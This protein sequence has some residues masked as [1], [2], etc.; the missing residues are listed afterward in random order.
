[1][2]CYIHCVLLLQLLTHWSLVEGVSRLFE[3]LREG[4]ESVFP[5]SSL[6]SFYPEEVRGINILILNKLR[7]EY[8]RVLSI[9]FLIL[10]APTPK[11]GLWMIQHFD[12]ILSKFSLDFHSRYKWV[13]LS[14]LTNV[15]NGTSHR[16]VGLYWTK[17]AF[18]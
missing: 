5:L 14:Y 15:T 13:I 9:C 17:L 12:F 6:Q 4:F 3:S 16:F 7:C 2:K 8:E 1:M 10:F 11:Y 18:P